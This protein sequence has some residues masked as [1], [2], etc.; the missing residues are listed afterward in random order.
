MKKLLLLLGCLVSLV[1]LVI[2]IINI[3][4]S[5][6]QPQ[7]SEEQEMP[8]IDAEIPHIFY[9]MTKSISIGEIGENG[10]LVGASEHKPYSVKYALYLENGRMVIFD[11]NTQYHKIIMYI[12]SE[13]CEDNTRYLFA[14][15]DQNEKQGYVE[16]DYYKDGTTLM[17]LDYSDYVIGYILETFMPQEEFEE[18]LNKYKK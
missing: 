12:G 2:G 9:G 4:S 7:Q 16:F 14:T 10:E 11:D 5:T 18:C 17:M 15:Y 8:E 13:E 3:S 6:K 1:A